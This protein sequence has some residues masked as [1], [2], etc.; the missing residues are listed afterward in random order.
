MG[1][2][3]PATVIARATCT[4]L[5]CA[6]VFISAMPRAHALRLKPGSFVLQSG[7]GPGFKLGSTVG[8]SPGY[9]M[10]NVGGEYAVSSAWTAIVD[11]SL[12]LADTVPVRVRTG[13]RFR[14]TGLGVPFLPYAQVQS[15]F[16]R[17]YGVLGADLWVAGG[18]VGIGTDYFLTKDYAVGALASADLGRTLGARPAFYGSFEFFIYAARVYGS[19]L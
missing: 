14:L 8:G 6:A 19:G 16:G 13:G 5:L 12:G 11:T 10:L 4:L 7:M 9:V 2:A 1:H 15:S 17:L 3:K 18:R